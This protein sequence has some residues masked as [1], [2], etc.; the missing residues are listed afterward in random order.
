MKS[1]HPFREG[2]CLIN[3]LMWVFTSSC[4]VFLKIF[5]QPPKNKVT[6]LNFYPISVKVFGATRQVF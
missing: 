6:L 3:S 1:A 5:R 4:V 2:P